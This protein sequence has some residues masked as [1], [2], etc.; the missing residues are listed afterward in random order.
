MCPSVDYYDCLQ[1]NGRLREA[2]RASVRHASGT[3]ASAQR[4]S[5]AHPPRIRPSPRHA[6]NGRFVPTPEGFTF[7]LI[8][9]LCSIAASLRPNG[10]PTLSRIRSVSPPNRPRPVLLAFPPR[11]PEIAIWDVRKPRRRYGHRF[12]KDAQAGPK[13]GLARITQPVS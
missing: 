8:G 13:G 6:A 2:L 10:Q 9:L 7:S 4:A 11:E 12:V 1:L 3:S 5:V